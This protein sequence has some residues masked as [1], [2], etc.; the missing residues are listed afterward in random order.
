MKKLALLLTVALVFSLAACTK[1]VEIPEEVTMENIDQFL[2]R[3]NV[4]LVDLRNYSDKMSAGY[5]DGFE[6]IS[7]FEYLDGNAVARND[8]WNWQ[9]DNLLDQD[10]LENFFDKE[11]EAI[12]M[13]CAGGTRAGFIKAALEEIGYTNAFNIGGFGDY[14]GE[15][16]VMGDSVYGKLPAEVT[17]ANVDQVLEA[18]GVQLVDLRDWDDKM[19][20]GYIAG[21]EFIPFFDYLE[22]QN[23]LVRN[24]GWNWQ[25]ANVLDADILMNFFDQNAKAIYLM[26][27]S[28]T[29][30]GFVKS[31][32]ESL[33]YTNVH[34]V[35]GIADYAG[36]NKVLGDSVYVWPAA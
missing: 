14:K 22:V 23:V 30:A 18:D 3:D 11:A 4:Q 33:G 20:S 28:G 12:F 29:R 15:N 27:G 31:A 10:L 19:K 26:C 13:M 24:D 5:I 16:K 35:G 2:E 7:F 1:E 34:N 36:E 32:L 21:F 9:A 17:M 6:I 8:G 25:D